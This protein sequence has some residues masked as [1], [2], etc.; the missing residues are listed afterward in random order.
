M[1]TSC[2]KEYTSIEGFG[3]ITTKT[4]QIDEF[5]GIRMEVGD[6]VFIKYGVEQKVTVTGHPNIISRIKT[7]V[8]NNTWNIELERGSYGQ[9]ELTYYLTLPRIERIYN[10]GT[11]DVVINDFISQDELSF[12]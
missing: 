7:D 2:K 3:T 9:Y 4:L 10:F 8:S 1:T 11:G 6:N 5:I 12:K